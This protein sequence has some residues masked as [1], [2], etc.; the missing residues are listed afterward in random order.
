MCC[1]MTDICPLKT[2]LLMVYEQ[3]A[4][5]Y[6]AAVGEL[7]RL[8]GTSSKE[9]YDALYHLAEE[10]QRRAAAAKQQLDE[11]VAEHGC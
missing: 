1:P 7:N 8:M 6:S 4:R 11:H 5:A 9:T 2:T 10:A 3:T